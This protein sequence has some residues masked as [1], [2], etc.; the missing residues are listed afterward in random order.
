MPLWDLIDFMNVLY[1]PNYQISIEWRDQAEEVLRAK[2]EGMTHEQ[3]KEFVHYFW[4]SVHPAIQIKNLAL[5]K[6]A[7]QVVIINDDHSVGE[8]LSP[9]EASSKY[10]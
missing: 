2:G 10:P 9:Q 6:D 8:I 4:R 5:S 1:V 3:I 7:Q